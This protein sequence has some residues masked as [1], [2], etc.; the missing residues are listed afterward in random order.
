MNAPVID[1]ACRTCSHITDLGNV[2]HHKVG[3][4]NCDL[5]SPHIFV[6]GHHSCTNWSARTTE[7]GKEGL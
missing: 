3:L 7:Q 6:P 2:A 1:H 5:K 4:R